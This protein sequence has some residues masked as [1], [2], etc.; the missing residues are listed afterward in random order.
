[1]SGRIVASIACQAI[2]G[3]TTAQAITIVARAPRRARHRTVA[4]A[5][6]GNTIELR[7]PNVAAPSARNATSA[8]VRGFTLPDATCE[9]ERPPTIAAATAAARN[10]AAKSWFPRVAPI[11]SMSDGSEVEAS[12]KT[13]IARPS[14]ATTTPL[15]T[16]HRRARSLS[17]SPRPQ[18]S[19]ASAPAHP[20]TIAPP[21]W[22]SVLA[23]RPTEASTP[24]SAATIVTPT[25]A[26]A[27]QARRRSIGR[28]EAHKASVPHASTTSFGSPNGLA[29]KGVNTSGRA[30]TSRNTP[31]SASC[32]RRA[33]ISGAG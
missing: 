15:T 13:L 29:E 31:S 14:T 27:A 28:P 21:P 32:G 25:H 12:G 26:A 23:V 33:C 16:N 19:T 6:S 20:R 7:S 17:S 9:P 4:P 18:P 22:P 24:V 5:M 10:A 3:T 8:T 30:T 2:R 11:I 1:M